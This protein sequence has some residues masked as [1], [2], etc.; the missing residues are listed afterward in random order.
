MGQQVVELPVF[1]R[2][3]QKCFGI[4]SNVRQNIFLRLLQERVRYPLQNNTWAK[5]ASAL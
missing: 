1:L 2:K 4:E 3:R 5:E